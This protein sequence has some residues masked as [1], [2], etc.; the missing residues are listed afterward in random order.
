MIATDF[1][2]TGEHAH[3]AGEAVQAAFADRIKTPL[4]LGRAD[5]V[6]TA[7]FAVVYEA[8][9]EVA[10]YLAGA[11]DEVAVDCSAWLVPLDT[12]EVI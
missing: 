1:W 9:G 3:E 6:P 5:G 11:F 2:L 4:V 7:G 10:L 12:I 8:M